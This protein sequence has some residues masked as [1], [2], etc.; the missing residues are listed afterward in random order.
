MSEIV[1]TGAALAT[2]ET[3]DA[4]IEVSLVHVRRSRTE[5]GCLFHAVHR[6]VE[7]PLRLVF[8]ERWASSAAL[9]AHFAVPESR[10]FVRA[11]PALGRA[12]DDRDLRRV[13]GE[14]LTSD[15]RAPYARRVR[16]VEVNG[17]RVSA[18]GLGTWQF[19][20][21][22]WGYGTDYA[23]NEAGRIVDR[24]LDL[25]VNLVDTAEVYGRGASE[26][27]VGRAIAHRRDEVFLATKV[28]PG[29]ADRER[30]RDARP[31]ESWSVSVSTRSTSTRSTGRIPRCRSGSRCGA[32]SALVDAGLVA[33]VRREQLRAS[34]AGIAAERRLG[35]P[36]LSN[37]V[38]Y[39]LAFRKPDEELVPYAAAT[40]TVW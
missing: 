35:A 11:R 3:I 4:M 10:E 40:T 13:A 14:P 26:R 21:N 8:V 32:C 12:A 24:A 31:Q 15:G 38:Q 29:H 23:D 18:I 2:A 6:D 16:F 36:V 17:V 28:L 25:G 7:E 33:H 22:D 30:R 9:Q 27:I 34:I 37:Q 19:G 39:S 5:P 1:V 20:S